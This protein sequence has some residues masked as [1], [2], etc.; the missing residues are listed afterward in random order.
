MLLPSH[1]GN[2]LIHTG[3]VFW[4]LTYI[5]AIYVA[6]QHKV[7]SIPCFSVAI[8]FAWEILF[9]FMVKQPS[10]FYAFDAAACFLDIIIFILTFMYIKKEKFFQGKAPIRLAFITLWLFSFFLIYFLEKE[11]PSYW[12]RLSGYIDNIIM[13]YLFCAM[14]WRRG[15]AIGQ[16]PW[17]AL[18]KLLGT[19][20]ITIGNCTILPFSWF[21]LTAGILV[22]LLDIYYLSLLILSKPL[23]IARSIERNLL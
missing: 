17:L 2:I 4:L 15:G 13:S 3:G 23:F 10:L 7:I 22:A 1:I 8:N 11:N 12:M 6:Y 21:I 14:Y 20:L 19:F 16:S 18:F 5:T 9:I